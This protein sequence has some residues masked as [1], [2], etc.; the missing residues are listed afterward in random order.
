[1]ARG[2][3]GL[4]HIERETVP[5]LPLRRDMTYTDDQEA[6]LDPGCL[7]EFALA[8]LAV[9]Q[10]RFGPGPLLHDTQHGR[11][12]EGRSGTRSRHRS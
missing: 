10:T 5:I 2:C 6:N 1:M 8:M 11:S 12:V 7:E 4:L 3:Q 9:D